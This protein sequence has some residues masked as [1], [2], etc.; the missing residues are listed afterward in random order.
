MTNHLDSGAA[1]DGVIRPSSD[2]GRL[3]SRGLGIQRGIHQPRIHV[4]YIPARCQS[5]G[6][7]RRLLE[8]TNVGCIPNP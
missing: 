8:E 3:Q 2:S 1:I 6:I 5:S 4:G 7:T